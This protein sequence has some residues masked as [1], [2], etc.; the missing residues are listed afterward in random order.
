[1]KKLINYLTYIAEQDLG[2]YH[3]KMVLMLLEH[4]QTQTMIADKLGIAK[5][6]MNKVA[7]DLESS[8]YIVIDRIE[9]RN[10]FFRVVTDIGVLQKALKGQMKL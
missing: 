10:K 6:N 7:K 4:P 1:M 8:G 5:Q 9:G 2:T 3:Y